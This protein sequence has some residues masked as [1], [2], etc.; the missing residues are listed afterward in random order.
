MFDRLPGLGWSALAWDDD[1]ADAEVVQGV[2]HAWFAVATVG[3]HGRRLAPG[4]FH[5]AFD[6]GCGPGRVGGVAGFDGV[7]EHDPVVV[8]AYLGFE[9]ELD[10]FAE[11]TLGDRPGLGVVQAD[12]AGRRGCQIVCESDPEGR[13][14][15]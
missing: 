7:V 12:P 5:Y 1:V 6:R 8:V 10:R 4:P 2:V 13:V 14:S 15:T 9:A 11:P 3:G